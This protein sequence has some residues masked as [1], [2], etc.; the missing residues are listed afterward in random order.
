MIDQEQHCDDSR[1]NVLLFGDEQS[2]EFLDSASHVE[3]CPHCQDRLTQLAAVQTPPPDVLGQ[4]I[5]AT[6]RLS[7]RGVAFLT[8][9]R[10]ELP[11][12][13]GARVEVRCDPPEP[14]LAP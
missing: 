6:D 12:F 4:A 8:P 5:R 9:G 1:L 3:S 13:G 2:D 10:F 14:E 7:L 11:D